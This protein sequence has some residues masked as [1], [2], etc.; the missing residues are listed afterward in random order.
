MSDDVIGDESNPTAEEV[1]TV[2]RAV[3]SLP[4]EVERLREELDATRLEAAHL[5]ET[6]A[7]LRRERGDLAGAFECDVADVVLHR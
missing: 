4:E 7:R 1:E 3:A 5:D 6:G 2:I